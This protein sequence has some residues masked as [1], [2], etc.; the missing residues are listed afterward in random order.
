[1]LDRLPPTL[2]SPP[3]PTPEEAA[4]LLASA[5]SLFVVGRGPTF[6]IAA[7]AALKLKETSG[8]HAEAFSSAEAL[9]GPAGVISEGFPLL[10]F[11]P[12]DA[13]RG[14]FFDAVER[15]VSFGGRAVLVDVEPHNHWPT[16]VAPDAG[17]PIPT[18]IAALYRFYTLA[19]MIAGRRG[20]DPDRP[21]HLM[22]VTRTV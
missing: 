6:A 7:E 5:S 12:T 17:H 10:C 19:E 3:R 11:A 15:L 20:R 18:A 13:A 16:I 22:K 2:E 21:P 14:A 4:G 8:I 9:H 1:V